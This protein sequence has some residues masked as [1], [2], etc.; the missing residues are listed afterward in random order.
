MIKKMQDNENEVTG[1][2]SDSVIGW[3]NLR[4]C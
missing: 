3:F 1:N 4:S 2:E